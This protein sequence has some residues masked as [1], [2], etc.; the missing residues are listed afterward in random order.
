MV[1]YRL[2]FCKIGWMYS[3]KSNCMAP[4]RGGD[5]FKSVGLTRIVGL[6]CFGG[7][8]T[9]LVGSIERFHAVA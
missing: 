2:K 1:M 7:S 9:N 6:V 3:Y 5:P 4:E 8:L